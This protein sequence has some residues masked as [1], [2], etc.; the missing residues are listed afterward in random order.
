MPC[1]QIKFLEIFL[2][3]MTLKHLQASDAYLNEQLSRQ[4]GHAGGSA[5]YQDKRSSRVYL[6]RVSLCHASLQAVVA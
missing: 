5:I 3:H 1:E 4:T 6:T 2:N